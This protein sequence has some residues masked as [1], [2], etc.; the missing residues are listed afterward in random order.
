MTLFLFLSLSLSLIIF[1]IKVIYSI[2]WGESLYIKQAF[3]SYDTWYSYV[4]LLATN[5][6]VIITFI[7]LGFDS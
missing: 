6:R 5:C 3:S 1:A 4:V 7:Y 2:Y